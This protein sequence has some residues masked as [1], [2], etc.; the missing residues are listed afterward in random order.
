[1]SRT[2][3]LRWAAPDHEVVRIAREKLGLTRDELAALLETDAQSVQRM[4]MHPECSTHRK[5]P[6]RVKRLLEAYLWGWRPRDWPQ[7]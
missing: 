1:M 4:E 7:R 2:L 3:N 6:N 5:P